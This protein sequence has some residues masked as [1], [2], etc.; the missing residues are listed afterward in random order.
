MLSCNYIIQWFFITRVCAS[1]SDA[2]HSRNY[3]KQADTLPMLVFWEVM[4]F[5]ETYCLHP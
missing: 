1:L 2:L 4:R 5:G 3:L